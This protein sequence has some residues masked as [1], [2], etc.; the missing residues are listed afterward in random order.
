MIRKIVVGFVLFCLVLNGG[1][2]VRRL[3][4]VQ[5]AQQRSKSSNELSRWEKVLNLKRGTRIEATA[6]DGRIIKGKLTEAAPDSI[7]IQDEA[8]A[9]LTK[10]ERDDVRQIRRG[11]MSSS[12]SA[13]LGALIGAG[14]GAGIIA[15]LASNE[16]IDITAA[17]IPAGVGIYA[18]IGALIGYAVSKGKGK[19]IYISP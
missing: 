16:D 7:S 18:G 3:D 17:A 8:T 15:G 12:R 14:A 2:A 6:K 5:H 11:K 19:L 4:T 9:R 1:C 13:L 10:L